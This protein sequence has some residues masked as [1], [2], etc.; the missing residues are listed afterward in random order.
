MVNGAVSGIDLTSYSTRESPNKSTALVQSA[1]AKQIADNQIFII[2]S[3]FKSKSAENLI[4]T[5]NFD[6]MSRFFRC[7]ISAPKLVEYYAEKSSRPTTRQEP[8]ENI[9]I[10][11]LL[12]Q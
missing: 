7:H 5:T 12:S 6:V 10:A 3:P 8:A 4:P 1:A 11:M 2:L 9:N